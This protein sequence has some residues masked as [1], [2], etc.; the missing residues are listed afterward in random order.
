MKNLRETSIKRCGIAISSLIA[1]VVSVVTTANSQQTLSSKC[2]NYFDSTPDYELVEYISGATTLEAPEELNLWCKTLYEEEPNARN[3]YY[4]GISQLL[5]DDSIASIKVLA[6]AMRE[7]SLE[8]RIILAVIVER[9]FPIRALTITRD[10]AEQGSALAMGIL[11]FSTL[12][13]GSPP[14]DYSEAFMWLDRGAG[15]GDARSMLGLAYMYAK[16]L[17][18]KVDRPAALQWALRASQLGHAQA[19]AMAGILYLSGNGVPHLPQEGFRLLL[20]AA[21][22]GVISAQIAVASQYESGLVVPRDPSRADYWRSVV[23]SR[24]SKP[25][26]VD[27]EAAKLALSYFDD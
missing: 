19:T 15:Q 25:F 16:G 20:Q 23:R 3:A 9:D 27:G 24:D 21:E 26:R 13:R 8:A 17:G 18:R 6:H 5:S 22:A 1:I 11:G 10:A 2:Q 4:L 14:Q 12:V 7:G